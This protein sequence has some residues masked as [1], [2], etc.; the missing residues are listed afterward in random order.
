MTHLAPCLLLWATLHMWLQLGHTVDV[1]VAATIAPT[2]AMW[3]HL[4]ILQRLKFQPPHQHLHGPPT[5][6]SG[7]KTTTTISRV[8]MICLSCTPMPPALTSNAIIKPAAP[9]RILRNMKHLATCH[10][11]RQSTMQ[12]CPSTLVH[13]KLDKK[14]QQ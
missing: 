2:T 12:S 11:E 8:V 10:Q 3:H 4:P 14:G 6:T 5:T 1:I 9:A 7:S 13:T